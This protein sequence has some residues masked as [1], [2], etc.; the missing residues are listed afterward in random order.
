MRMNKV[1][2]EHINETLYHEEL[3]NGLNVYILP[4]PGFSK[5][6][7]TFSTKYGSIDNHFV[8]V[9]EKDFITVPDGIAHFLEHKMFAT[10]T[11][12][13]FDEFTKYAANSNAFTSFN[14]TVYLFSCT[15]HFEENLTTL[16]NMCQ[17]VYLTDENVEKEKGIIAQEIKMYDDNPDWRLYFGTI[18]NMYKENVVRV[19]I[20]GTV[21]SIYQITKETLTACFNTFY[22]PRNM[23]LFI[24]GDVDP[25]V[26]M[27]L[28]KANQNAKTFP[29][30]QEL[31]RTYIFE[32][33][34]VAR[35]S[36]VLH[37]DVLT[38][39]A[40]VG[41]KDHLS[42][43][44]GKDLMK[45]EVLLEIMFEYLFSKSSDH[46]QR[47]LEQEL[48]NDSFSYDLSL[49]YSFG[50]GIISSDTKKPEELT[51]AIKEILLSA[52][53]LKMTEEEF[54]I[55]KNKLLGRSIRSL[56]N[57]E[58]IATAFT[59]YQFNDINM[60]DALKVYD[61]LTVADLE[62]VRDFFSE[63]AITELIIYPKTK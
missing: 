26:T 11:G 12:D 14:R 43:R 30:M 54:T 2:Y 37:M 1:F 21:D 41:V 63:Q 52:R 13:V 49:E 59:R 19:D 57:I 62:L 38:P 42:K 44:Q 55:V 16:I 39:K 5:Y 3:D 4:K 58:A 27:N 17:E 25:E 33:N 50:F 7:A 53:D 24:V 23:M 34:E 32:T 56:N 10:P 35:K 47:L 20:A 28:I 40:A 46:Y 9:G 31:E 8:P 48:I 29:E 61:E 60:F 6:F 36:Q 15:S 45:Y 18:E 51:K 22:H